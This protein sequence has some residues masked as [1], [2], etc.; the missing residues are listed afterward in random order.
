MEFH[1]TTPESRL[2][3][4]VVHI[5]FDGNMSTTKIITGIPDFLYIAV[6]LDDIASN[7]LFRTKIIN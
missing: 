2:T 3:D 1:E 7:S 6:M 4:S 5:T